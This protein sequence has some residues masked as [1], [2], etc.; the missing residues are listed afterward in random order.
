MIPVIPCDHLLTEEEAD[1]FAEGLIQQAQATMPEA[2]GPTIGEAIEEFCRETGHT[3]A[4]VGS[5]ESVR[6]EFATWAGKTYEML[7]N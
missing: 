3:E 4:E 6:R 1:K 2:S 7:G 5:S